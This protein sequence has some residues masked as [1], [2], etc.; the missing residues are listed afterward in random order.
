MLSAAQAELVIIGDRLGA[1]WFL[2]GLSYLSHHEGR[3][4][5]A[6]NFFAQAK[7]QFEELGLWTQPGHQE[8][9]NALCAAL[10]ISVRFARPF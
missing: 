5:E 6:Q 9:S 3:L 2:R 8:C 1:A 10:T 7:E 4:D